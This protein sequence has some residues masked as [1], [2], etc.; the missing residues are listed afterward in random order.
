MNISIPGLKP[1]KSHII[2]TDALINTP[3]SELPDPLPDEG[4]ML[5][6]GTADDV[7]FF[8]WEF[9]EFTQCSSASEDDFKFVITTDRLIVYEKPTSKGSISLPYFT[10]DDTLKLDFFSLKQI[11]LYSR[12]QR[13]LNHKG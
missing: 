9:T 11:N 4:D 13:S 7:K 1:N 10:C 5:H 12:F 2:G 8:A 6:L 3:S